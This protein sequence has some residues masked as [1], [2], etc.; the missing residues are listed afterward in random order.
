MESGTVSRESFGDAG[1]WHWGA[2]F[3]NM[4]ACDETVPAL[5]WLVACLAGVRG[6]A[7]NEPTDWNFH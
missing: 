2:G 1:S 6:Y 7:W 5:G 4:V 3:V